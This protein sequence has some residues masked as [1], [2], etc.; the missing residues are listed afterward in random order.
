VLPPSVTVRPTNGTHD[1]AAITKWF[2]E[3]AD[4]IAKQFDNRNEN[5]FFS[6]MLTK[7]LDL[8]SLRHSLPLNSE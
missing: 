1:P 8:R 4:E 3:K 6:E 7:T 2:Y 5:S